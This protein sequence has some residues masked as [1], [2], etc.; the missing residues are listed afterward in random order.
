MNEDGNITFR[1]AKTFLQFSVVKLEVR[2]IQDF[3]SAV[4]KYSRFTFCLFCS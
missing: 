3:L 2:S 4:L 1:M